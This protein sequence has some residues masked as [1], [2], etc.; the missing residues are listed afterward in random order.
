MTSG[1]PF[2]DTPSSCGFA[3]FT[4]VLDL[5]ANGQFVKRFTMAVYDVG[6]FLQGLKFGSFRELQSA[7]QDYPTPFGF[8]AGVSANF[9]RNPVPIEES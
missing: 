8:S 2:I 4:G 7:I 1:L 9:P 5:T 3:A 6:A